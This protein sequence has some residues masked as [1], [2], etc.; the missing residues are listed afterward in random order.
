[1]TVASP[2][3]A[4]LVTHAG[5]RSGRGIA[6]SVGDA[7]LKS[8]WGNALIR[9]PCHQLRDKAKLQ[10]IVSRLRRNLDRRLKP[11]GLSWEDIVLQMLT[12]LLLER[13]PVCLPE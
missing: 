5:C 2:T 10:D 3:P 1:M 6:L 4:V 8:Q 13:N 11:V 9:E 12:P 7:N